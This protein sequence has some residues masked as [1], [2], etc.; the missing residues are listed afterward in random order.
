MSIGQMTGP[1]RNWFAGEHTNSVTRVN[2]APSGGLAPGAW[3]LPLKAGGIASRNEARIAI[4]ATGAGVLGRNISGSASITLAASGT[5]GL[6][7]SATG[8]AS[9]SLSASGGIYATRA[10]AGSASLS[11]AANGTIRGTGAVV[12]TAGIALAA[13][14]TAYAVGWI[15]GTTANVETLTPTSVALAVRAELALELSRLDEAISR[16]RKAADTAA[17]LSA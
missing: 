10:V 6:I 2:G 9:I 12:G 1:R 7:S 16:A 13:T 3:L 4:A 17:A 5:G 15:S 11:L 14:Q 8:T